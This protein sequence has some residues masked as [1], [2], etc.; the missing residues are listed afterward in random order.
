MKPVETI[1]D[2]L[3]VVVLFFTHLIYVFSLVQKYELA[4]NRSNRET[5]FAH[6]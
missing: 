4:Y 1:L 3:V 5:G 2:R 6:P